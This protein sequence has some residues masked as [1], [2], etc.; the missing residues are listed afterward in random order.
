M[1]N[2]KTTIKSLIIYLKLREILHYNLSLPVSGKNIASYI[3]YLSQ[4]IYIKHQ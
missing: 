4:S 3:F 2:L 1:N